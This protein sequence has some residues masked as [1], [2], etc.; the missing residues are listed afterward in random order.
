MSHKTFQ[1]TVDAANAAIKL[2]PEL[3]ELAGEPSVVHDEEHDAFR[4]R[5]GHELPCPYIRIDHEAV[6]AGQ[7]NP[8]AFLELVKMEMRGLLRVLG[9]HV[10]PR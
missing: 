2:Y 8:D 3:V 6:L 9:K 4:I 5:F 10:G 7:S 1:A